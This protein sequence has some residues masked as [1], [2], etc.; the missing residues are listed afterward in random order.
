MTHK[1]YDPR[2][3]S[4][5]YHKVSV[6]VWNKKDKAQKSRAKW[7]VNFF[8]SQ[9]LVNQIDDLDIERLEEALDKRELS[10]STIN[11][12]YSALSSL[13][14]YAKAKPS[15]Y[16]KDF[17]PLH[18]DW[19]E[20]GSH[21]LRFMQPE[22]ELRLVEILK[23]KKMEEFLNLY[24]FQIDTGLR[25]SETIGH[26]SNAP[27]SCK[28]KGF[29]VGDVDRSGNFINLYDRKHMNNNEYSIIPLI[30]RA[31]EIVLDLCVGKKADEPVF[32][33]NYWAVQ[34][35][36]R[37]EV[38]TAFQEEDESFCIHMLRHT[39]ASRLV[40]R[41]VDIY[42]VKE[43][44]GHK[45]IKTTMQYAKLNNKTVMDAMKVLS[46]NPGTDERNHFPVS[47]AV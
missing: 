13:I 8:G 19:R 39:T 11:H 31:K 16:G 43:I 9:K 38:R 15:I 40:Q 17:E 30:P 18:F 46:H 4:E 7:L 5:L 2:T 24:L 35:N 10:G 22:E 32:P 23:A 28:K 3:I 14:K 33:N 34:R 27:A 45:D 47:V 25:L 36:W 37:E 20:K 6:K 44:M 26:N 29:L 42:V 41:G 1:K 21:R 12:Y